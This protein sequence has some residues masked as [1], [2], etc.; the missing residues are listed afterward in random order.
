MLSGMLAGKVGRCSRCMRWSAVGTLA[1][2]TAVAGTAWRDG[3]ALVSVGALAGAGAFSLLLVAHVWTHAVRAVR[4]VRSHGSSPGHG[5]PAGL[6]RRR[7]VLIGAR[8]VLAGLSLAAL[9]RVPAALASPACRPRRVDEPVEGAGLFE[10]D[11]RDDLVRNATEH[12]A[13][14]VCGPQTGC[15]GSDCAPR[16]RPRL[17]RDFRDLECHDIPNGVQCTATLIACRCRCER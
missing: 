8:A 7:F 2:W 3:P 6:D 11:A 5:S 10:Q 1:G 4:H 17:E 12:C 16:P 14:M 13:D 15:E 9:G